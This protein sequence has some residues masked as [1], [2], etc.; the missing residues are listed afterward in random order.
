MGQGMNLFFTVVKISLSLCWTIP[1]RR[2]CFA[3]TKPANYTTDWLQMQYLPT[4]LAT[5]N[6]LVLRQ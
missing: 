3:S 5:I 2:A 4:M 6:T 1:T